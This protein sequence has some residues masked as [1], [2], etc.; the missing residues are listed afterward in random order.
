[1]TEQ[2]IG[3]ANKST[4]RFLSLRVKIWIGFILIF[5]PVFVASYYWFYQYTTARVFQTITDQLGQ[6][7]DGTIKGM[8]RDGFV[9][10]FKEESANNPKC[11]PAKDAPKEENGYYPEDNPLY[12]AHENW[13][14]AV[15]HIEPETRIYTYIKGIEPGEIIA[16]G[17]TGY[18]REP[19]GGFRFCQRYT[20][21]SSNIFNGLTKQVNAW[22]PYTDSFGSWITTYEPIHDD[23]GTIIGAIGIDI[24]ANYVDEVR[25]SILVSGAIAFVLSYVLIFFLVY[26]LSGL[27]THP[28]VGLASV[29]KE[30]GEGDY[31][32]EWK[33]EDVKRNFREEIDTLTSV[34][35]VMV[36]KVAQ[37]EKTLRARVHQ[38]EIMVDKSKLDQ[39][40]QEIVESDFF[41]DLQSKV[42]GM[43]DR[44]KKE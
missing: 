27:L 6:T 21:T 34:F 5:T 1:M 11:P 24:S 37:R 33:D 18:F 17:S 10:L 9:Q 3:S 12:I 14:L 2:K 7:I 29:A 16:I 20:S 15:Q 4:G 41:Q 32:H 42:R 39:Q 36:D 8:D 19:R 44:F 28:I 22:E 43:R 31:S 25:N 30:I 40:V 38:L 23:G 26:W 35:K 13:L